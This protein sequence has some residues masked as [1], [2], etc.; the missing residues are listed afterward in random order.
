MAI[1]IAARIMLPTEFCCGMLSATLGIGAVMGEHSMWDAMEK[2]PMWF[3]QTQNIWWGVVMI[4]VGL[5]LSA[6]AVYELAFGKRWGQEA[7]HI[8]ADMRCI[9][10]LFLVIA[11]TSLFTTICV[12][13]KHMPSFSLAWFSPIIAFFS[14]WS[15]WFTR[16]LSIAL[17]PRYHTPGLSE[18][19]AG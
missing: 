17:N 1:K 6:I 9:S 7:L 8:F 2:L 16:R 15:A 10:A 5:I 13:S 11:H 19:I 18:K 12:E 4:S 14:V 3:G